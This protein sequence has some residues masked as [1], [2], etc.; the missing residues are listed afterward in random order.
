MVYWSALILV[1]ANLTPL[2]G[3]LALDWSLFL[4]M[5]LYWS[6]S[7][8]IAFFTLLKLV[9]LKDNPASFHPNLNV[10][11]WTLAA[12]SKW[13]KAAYFLSQFGAFMFGH[14]IF[15]FIIFF[16]QIFTG[17]DL[18]LLLEP[19]TWSFS[20][21]FLSHAVSYG[22]NYWGRKEYLHMK[23]DFL[24]STAYSRMI[25]MHFVLMGC[26]LM[27][28]AFDL[29]APAILMG[30]AVVLKIAVDLGVHFKGHRLIER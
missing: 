25:Y 3:V 1:L 30:F 7:A 16:D 22:L 6:E 24:F 26:F 18:L 9:H 23:T 2:Y 4:L 8:I 14:L 27:R 15:I 17:E 28:F 13:A 29:N 21:L 10:P 11:N 20:L 5:F 12:R 19:F